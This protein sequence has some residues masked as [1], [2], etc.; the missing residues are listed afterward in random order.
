MVRAR[1]PSRARP[2][3]TPPTTD[4]NTP[5]PKSSPALAA[6]LR[7]LATHASW[8]FAQVR[9][10]P[11]GTGCEL[12]HVDDA[13]QPA[14]SLATRDVDALAELAQST[15][16]GAFRP[17]KTAPNLRRGWRCVTSSPADLA[18]ALEALYPGAVADWWAATHATPP[19]QHYREF[20]ARQTGMYRSTQLLTDAEAAAVTRACCDARSCLRRRLWTV[21]GLSPD[22]PDAGKSVIPCLE[23]CPLML[24]FARRGRRM[25]Q[26]ESI[27]VPLT[28]EDLAL[29]IEALEVARA[30]PASDLREGDLS[31]PLN[32]RRIQLL[33]DRLRGL[34]PASPPAAKE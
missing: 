31:Q 25:A 33:Q 8:A 24:E 3:A 7:E 11:D 5:A 9:L 10:T 19:V 6:L 21:P 32:P 28:A 13:D 14:E 26:A 16:T 2:P 18:E 27:P 17:I 1:R 20:T 30:H 23:P 4:M 22:G 34:L 29:M 12:R 15:A